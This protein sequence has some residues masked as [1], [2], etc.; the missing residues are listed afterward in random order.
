MKFFFIECDLSIQEATLT[1]NFIGS[2]LDPT[3]DFRHIIHT[4]CVALAAVSCSGC[5][6]K[7]IVMLDV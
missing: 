7:E 5:M 4:K 2:Y 6:G 3:Q 1:F